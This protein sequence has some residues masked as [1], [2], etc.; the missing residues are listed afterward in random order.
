MTNE[1][2]Q[3]TNEARIPNDERGRARRGCD[4]KEGLR[5]SG[6]GF[7]SSFGF[8]HLSF[9]TLV[10]LPCVCLGATLPSDWQNEQKFEL[11]SSGL[12]AISLPVE[13]LN[14]SRPN[15]EDLRLYDDA[16][17]E[18]PYLIERPTTTGRISQPAKSFAATLNRASTV[19]TL[20]TG[21]SQPVDGI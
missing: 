11:S 12:T 19:V 10:L 17:N 13:T 2:C 16:G 1:T 18:V 8:R 9:A 6:L 4:V 14:K 20:E 5:D 3:M 7:L 21:V 15:L